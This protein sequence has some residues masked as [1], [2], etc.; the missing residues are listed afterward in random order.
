MLLYSDD[1]QNVISYHHYHHNETVFIDAF[2]L[3]KERH[4]SHK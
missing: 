1:L 4:V 3:E 2:D